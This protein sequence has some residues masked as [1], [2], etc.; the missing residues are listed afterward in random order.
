MKGSVLL[1]PDELAQ[2]VSWALGQAGVENING[3]A[4]YQGG[5]MVGFDAAV[6]EYEMP[7]GLDL[8]KVRRRDD[9]RSLLYPAVSTS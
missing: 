1:T 2:V 6:V 8:T 3:L 5:A 9:L 4:I 7:E